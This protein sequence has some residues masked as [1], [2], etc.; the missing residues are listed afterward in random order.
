MFSGANPPKDKQ[1]RKAVGN[2][3]RGVKKEQAAAKQYPT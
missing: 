2:K 3:A 1:K